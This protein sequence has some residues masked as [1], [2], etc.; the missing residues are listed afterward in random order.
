LLIR[1]IYEYYFFTFQDRGLEVPE[2]YGN[3][4]FRESFRVFCLGY[5]PQMEKL[6]VALEPHPWQQYRYP[7]AKKDKPDPSYLSNSRKNVENKK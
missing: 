3:A 5:K 1:K 4:R 7:L 6:E 2:I